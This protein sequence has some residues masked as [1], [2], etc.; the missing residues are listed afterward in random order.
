MRRAARAAVPEDKQAQFDEAGI[1]GQNMCMKRSVIPT[2]C[3]KPTDLDERTMAFINTEGVEYVKVNKNSIAKSIGKIPLYA[4]LI[5]GAVNG[6]NY[7]MFVETTKSNMEFI[8]YVILPAGGGVL[9]III[10]I[11]VML[12]LWRQ[13]KEV[14]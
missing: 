11:V 6:T 10:I 9:L 14:K 7:C 1:P 3:D 5:T 2:K 4:P 13:K 12:F 8:L